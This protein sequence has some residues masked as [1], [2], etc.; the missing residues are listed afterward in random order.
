VK[1]TKTATFWGG[2]CKKNSLTEPSLP[3]F[4]KEKILPREGSG[5]RT[6]KGFSNLEVLGVRSHLCVEETTR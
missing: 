2:D 5:A 4:L 1:K 6:F 3:S